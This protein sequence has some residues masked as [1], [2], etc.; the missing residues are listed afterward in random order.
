MTEA[1]NVTHLTDHEPEFDAGG[2]ALEI[3]D[4][5]VPDLGPAVEHGH[6]RFGHCEQLLDDVRCILELIGSVGDD[7]D[8]LTDDTI[9][10]AAW[11]ALRMVRVAQ[12]SH[13][14]PKAWEI[15]CAQIHAG[16][17]AEVFVAEDGDKATEVKLIDRNGD[18]VQSWI[19]RHETA[20]ALRNRK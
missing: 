13:R 9:P 3:L 19:V 5:L 10:H 6:T 14:D 4:L 16:E 7:G 11:L 1:T 17:G 18:L 2:H 12:G 20:E 15:I 8:A